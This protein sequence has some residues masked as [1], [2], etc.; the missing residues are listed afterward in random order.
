M[1][2]SVHFFHL[3]S[4]AFARLAC[5]NFVFSVPEFPDSCHAPRLDMSDRVL[6]KCVMMCPEKERVRR[7]KE[8]RLSVFEVATVQDGKPRT[9]AHLAVKEYVRSGAGHEFPDANELRPPPVL[10]QTVDHLIRNVA[11]RH[12]HPWSVV[13]SFVNDRIQA[14]RQDAT[15]QILMTS[16]NIT[17]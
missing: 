15:Y 1:V 14:I 3:H 10:V 17:T 7:E 5:G 12:D 8:R 9:S 16:P 13:Y 11:D 4:Q 6:G 2:G